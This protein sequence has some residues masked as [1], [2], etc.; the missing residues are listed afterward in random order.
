NPMGLNEI[1]NHFK[2]KKL[3]F[4]YIDALNIIKQKKLVAV[5]NEKE[6]YLSNLEF[7]E[8]YQVN[9]NLRDYVDSLL[10]DWSYSKYITTN[11]G[12]IAIENYEKYQKQESR[13]QSK[14]KS[15]FNQSIIGWLAVIISIIALIIS[16]MK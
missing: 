3:E 13:D 15:S 10:L 11:E 16:F 8:K 12:I 6:K 9:K 1:I 14:V 7:R 4:S 5:V 2:F